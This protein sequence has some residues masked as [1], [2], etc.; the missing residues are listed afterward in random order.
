M[1]KS[2]PTSG[3]ILLTYDYQDRGT[4]WCKLL[5]S[6]ILFRLVVP[7]LQSGVVAP[8]LVQGAWFPSRL[9]QEGTSRIQIFKP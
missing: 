5:P 1:R 6:L 3:K 8:Y 4:Y 9:P 2:G 7:P